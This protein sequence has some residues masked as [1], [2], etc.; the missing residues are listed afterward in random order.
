MTQPARQSASQNDLLSWLPR[1]EAEELAP[2]LQ[3]LTLEQKQQ[4]YRT[5]DT[6]THVY[7]PCSGM[8]SVLVLMEDGAEIEVGTVGR[9]GMISAAAVCGIDNVVHQVT[10]QL[11]GE[12]L[13][14]PR[15]AF[16]DALQRLPGLYAVMMRYLAFSWRCGHQLMACNALHALEQRMCRWLLMTHDRVDSDTF[17]LTQEF[18]AQML[19][20]RRPTVSEVASA[21]QRA[22]LIVYR[23]GE[24]QILN[25]RGLEAACCDC[26]QAIRKLHTQMLPKPNS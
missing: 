14:M 23:R 4:L 8:I 17:S 21:W 13:R 6:L 25:R 10:V 2:R 19:G 18:L 24:I 7:F 1:Q 11:P 9:E 20:V 3:R 5:G 26:Y 12:A 15:G 16:Q 22:G